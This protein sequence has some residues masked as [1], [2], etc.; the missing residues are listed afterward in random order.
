MFS[1][2]SFTHLH[3]AFYGDIFNSDP[4]LRQQGKSKWLS[5]SQKLHEIFQQ[6]APLALKEEA[7]T[8]FL[9]IAEARSPK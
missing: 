3:N 2:L 6:Y 7:S 1:S 5:S 8:E 4:T 9:E